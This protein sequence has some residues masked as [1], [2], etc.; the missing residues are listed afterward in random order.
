MNSV[1]PDPG[2]AMEGENVRTGKDRIASIDASRALVMFT[3]VFVNDIAGVS[4]KI[5]PWW[6][7]HLPGDANGMTFVDL[8]FPAF[9]FIVGMSIPFAIGGRLKRGEAIHV[10]LL[11]VGLRTLS[12]LGLGIL[13]VNGTPDSAIM[14]WSGALWGTCL[15]LAAIMAFSDLVPSKGIRGGEVDQFRSNL[16]RLLR[17]IGLLVLVWLAFS[18]RGAKGERIIALSPFSLRT[19]WYGILGLIGWAYLV[20]TLVFLAAGT[21]RLALL[22]CMVLLFCLYPADRNGL[23]EGFWLARFVGIGGTLGSQAAITVSGVLLATILVTPET[24]PPAARVRF[25]LLFVSGCSAAALLLHPLYEIN[26]NSATPSW[27]LWASAVTGLLWLLFY[28]G[29]DVFPAGPRLRCVAVAG[30]NVL[31]AYLLHNLLYPAMDILNVSS[32]YQR[33]AD[34]GLGFAVGRSLLCAFLVLGLASCLNRCGLR[35]RL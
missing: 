27:C 23:F 31:M 20:G 32:V 26:K 22:S 19:E 11:H 1:S 3:M 7:R 33:F 5:V 4:S 16:S 13:M 9:L 24:S 35:L 6:M 14:G 15:Y 21:R 10:V 34:A 28:L 18:F 12:L 17:Y 30:Q 8:V 2:K 25:T 29:L